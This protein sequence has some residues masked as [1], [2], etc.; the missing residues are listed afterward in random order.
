MA[1]A[2]EKLRK[3]QSHYTNLLAKLDPIKDPAGYAQA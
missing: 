1:A 2:L 3:E